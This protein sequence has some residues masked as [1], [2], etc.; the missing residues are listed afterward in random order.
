MADPTGELKSEVLRLAFD[1]Q[2]A[3]RPSVRH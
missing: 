1:P 2:G 3:V